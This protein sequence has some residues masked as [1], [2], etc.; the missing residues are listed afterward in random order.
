VRI[1]RS[2]HQRSPRLKPPDRVG[3]VW[4]WAEPDHITLLEVLELG[5]DPVGVADL[6]AG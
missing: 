6:A 5:D 4:F 3:R 2:Q 1:G